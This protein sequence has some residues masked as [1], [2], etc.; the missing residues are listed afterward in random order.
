MDQ[1]LDREKWNKALRFILDD[2]Q[3]PD[4][5]MRDHAH[6]EKFYYEYTWIRDSL[7][8]HAHSLWR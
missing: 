2:L 5:E 3:A 6:E 8:E 7:I 1:A 4:E